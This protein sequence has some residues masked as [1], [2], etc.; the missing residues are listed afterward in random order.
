[1][2]LKVGCKN[3]TYNKL[4]TE[5][6]NRTVSVYNPDAIVLQCGADYL[7]GDLLGNFNLTLKFH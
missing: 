2:P 3:E 7:M 4:F 1:M 6:L 5:V